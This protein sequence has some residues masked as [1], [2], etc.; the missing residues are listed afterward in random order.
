MIMIFL[1]MLNIYFICTCVC[2]FSL[3]SI[4]HSRFQYKNKKEIIWSCFTKEFSENNISVFFKINFYSCHHLFRTFKRLNVRWRR[5][6]IHLFKTTV[7]YIE[8]NLFCS[9]IYWTQ[10]IRISTWWKWRRNNEHNDFFFVNYNFLYY[11]TYF[12]NAKISS[13][14][15]V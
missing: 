5:T 7:T 8:R 13:S 11:L 14:I 6:D 3:L 1:T 10:H 9:P 4:P 15:V 2:F 12:L